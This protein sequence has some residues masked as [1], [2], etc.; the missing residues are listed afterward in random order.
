MQKHLHT[1]LTVAS[2]AALCISLVA[3][4]G[5]ASAAADSPWLPIPGQVSLSLNHTQQSAND[6][7]IGSMQLPISTITGGGASKYERST[8]R[9][10][11]GYG[12][13]DAVSLDA[14]LG[15]GKV[16]VGAADNDSGRLDSIVGVNWRVLDEYELGGAP[17]LT[18]RAAAIFK[19]SY[20]GNKLAALGNAQNGFELALI[21]G[22]EVLPGLAVW[23]EI[24]VVDRSGAVP[25]ATT[26]ELGVRYRFGGGFSASLGFAQEK[27]GGNL[28]IGA[29]GFSPARFQEVRAERSL[30]KL[31]L[32]YAFAGN[33]GLAL[34]FANTGSGRNTT[35]DNQIIGLGYTI[36][37]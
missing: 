18:L 16:K 26:A 30:T 1:T 36:G 17:T 29:P 9:L 22:K 34:S 8:T 6:A 3:L 28:D 10:R 7:Y 23:G 31:G 32:A 19:G 33:Q 11:V 27:Y 4:P 21:V 20:D 15:V 5:F 12:L 25:N 35:K 13:F 2:K 24:G 37:F 14:S